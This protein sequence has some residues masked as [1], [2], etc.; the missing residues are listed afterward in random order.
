VIVEDRERPWL[1][2]KRFLDPGKNPVK[3]IPGERVREEDQG[4]VIGNLKLSS[5]PK[6]ENNV[7]AQ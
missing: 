6:M 7:I 3:G 5:I 4:D 1:P 2:I